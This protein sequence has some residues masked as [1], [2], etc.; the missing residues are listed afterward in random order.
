MTAYCL[1]DIFN[2]RLWPSGRRTTYADVRDGISDF[3]G[4]VVRAV[5]SATEITVRLYG[6][7]HRRDLDARVDVRLMV[8]KAIRHLP[9]RQTTHRLRLQ[10]AD[11]P[12]S[13]PAPLMLGTL[14]TSSLSRLRADISPSAHCL[15]PADCTLSTFRAWASGHCPLPGCAVRL[16]DV[17]SQRRQKI[18]DTL[19]T[20][21]AMIIAHQ[22]MANAVAIASDDDDMVPAL[23]ALVATGLQVV[24][25]RRYQPHPE[26]RFSSYYPDI[27]EDEGV[28]IHH[29]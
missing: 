11:R 1:A 3:L 15:Q 9:K 21:D 23:L 2:L 19:L 16:R 6:G 18:V 8:A 13:S 14:R 17:A 7:W 20:T 5:P 25:L 29:W 28:A 26:H 10:L 12:V 24:C 22:A 27:L 4:E